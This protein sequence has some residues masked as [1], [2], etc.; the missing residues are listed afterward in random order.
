[1]FGNFPENLLS[2]ST[3]RYLVAVSGIPSLAGYLAVQVADLN[4][5]R[6]SFAFPSQRSSLGESRRGGEGTAF[7]GATLALIILYAVFSLTTF[8]FS[9]AFAR[10]NILSSIF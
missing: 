3:H 2:S 4:I 1:M 7:S 10:N 9:I 6:V 5:Y 8:P